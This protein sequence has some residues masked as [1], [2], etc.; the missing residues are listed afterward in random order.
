MIAVHLKEHEVAVGRDYL[1]NLLAE[2]RMLIRTRKRKTITTQSR[3]WM[4][5]YPNLIKE[6]HVDRPGQLWVSD[7]TYIR[8]SSGFAYLSLVTDAYSRKIIGY[9]IRKDLSS[10]GCLQAL[11]MAIQSRASPHQPLIHHSDRGSQYCCKQYVECLIANN[12]AISMTEGGDPYENALAERVNGIL[13]AEFDLYSSMLSFEQTCKTVEKS[14]AAYNQLRP[15]AS[16]DYLVPDQA[17]ESSGPLNK[18]WKNY[19]Q[20]LPTNP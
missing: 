12:I 13:K 11:D 4:R 6:I 5:K 9:N 10:E 20:V 2:H 14:I 17:H 3:H 1:F 8:L 7:I 19:T 15:H 18:R 16:C